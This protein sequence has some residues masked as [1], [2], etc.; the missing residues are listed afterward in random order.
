M[1]NL[2]SWVIWVH[3]RFEY[4]SNLST[5]TWAISVLHLS[6]YFWDSF[7]S[8]LSS[9]RNTVNKASFPWRQLASLMIYLAFSLVVK[10]TSMRRPCAHAQSPTASKFS[11]DSLQQESIVENYLSAFDLFGTC[12]IFPSITFW[13]Y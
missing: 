5:S 8:H 6:L 13:S 7:L 9:I 4:L 2:S 12:Y 10:C 11:I 1:S 3:E